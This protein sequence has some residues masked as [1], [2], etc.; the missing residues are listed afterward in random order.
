VTR[1]ESDRFAEIKRCLARADE[2]F[3]RA[4]VCE[5]ERERIHLIDEAESWLL[6]AEQVFAR[7]TDRMTPA[8]PPSAP[9]EEQRSFRG[10]AD[11]RDPGAVWD[12][13]GAKPAS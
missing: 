11:E 9:L 10:A 2:A 7:L 3:A 13:P 1:R 8:S 4:G 5:D 12:R 6:R